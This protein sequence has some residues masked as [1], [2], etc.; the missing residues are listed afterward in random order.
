MQNIHPLFVHFPLALLSTGLFFDFLGLTLRKESFRNAGW[1]C[2][3]FGIL[4]VIA[5]ATT[6]LMAEES[7]DH[8]TH[9]DQV[10][11]TLEL[12]ETLMLISAGLFA[13]L[14]VW[15]AIRKS[16]LPSRLPL[17]ALYF[18]IGAAASGTMFF[19]AHQGGR[20]VYEFGIGGTAVKQSAVDGHQVHDDGHQEDKP[21]GHDGHDEH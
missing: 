1:W 12:H 5:A 10:H 9:N 14:F 20:L 13:A 21:T 17:V 15:R 11:E 19:G 7:L 16:A 3:A 18:A 2:Q 4:A 8:S 6:G